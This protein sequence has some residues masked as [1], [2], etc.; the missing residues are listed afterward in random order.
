[1]AADDAA[2]LALWR[3]VLALHAAA[4]QRTL[5]LR[6]VRVERLRESSA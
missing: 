6:G 5:E 4:S 3:P 2:L 1:M